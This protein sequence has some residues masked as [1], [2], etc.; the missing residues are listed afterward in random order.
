MNTGTILWAVLIGGAISTSH[1][2]ANGTSPWRPAIGTFFVGV[3]LYLVSLANGQLAGMM[4]LL[5]F[6]TALLSNGSWLIGAIDRLTGVTP[7]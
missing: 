1:A 7:P 4:A 2:L 6:A 5:F 3:G